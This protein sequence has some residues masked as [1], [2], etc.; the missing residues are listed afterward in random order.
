MILDKQMDLLDKREKA[1]GVG[2]CDERN[3][4]SEE[5]LNKEAQS[6][7]ANYLNSFNTVTNI[8]SKP[9]ATLMPTLLIRVEANGK[10]MGPVR[11]FLD[12]GAE[13]NL[14]PFGL[15]DQLQLTAMPVSRKAIGIDG[16]PVQL[17][18]RVTARI[19]PWFESDSCIEDEFLVLP[20]GLDWS[21]FTPPTDVQPMKYK[22][23]VP[24][25]DPTYWKRSLAALLLFLPE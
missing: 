1:L 8:A 14:M 23:S 17:R 6:L 16:N 10:K 9:T 21:L 25:A 24:I 2:K 7:V 12:S 4:K 15:M 19:V 22:S 3:V 5:S 20:K 11:A 18:Q 13:M